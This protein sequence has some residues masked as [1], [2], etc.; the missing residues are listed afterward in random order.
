MPTRANEPGSA[1]RQGSATKRNVTKSRPPTSGSISN[2]GT[3]VRKSQKREPTSTELETRRDSKLSLQE[4]KNDKVEKSQ[5]PVDKN[6][7][8]DNDVQR[9]E[10]E[11]VV[12]VNDDVNDV[13]PEEQHVGDHEKDTEPVKVES[14][15]P[16]IPVVEVFTLEK[17]NQTCDEYADVFA[18]NKYINVHDDYPVEALKTLTNEVRDVVEEYK[19]ESAATQRH[20]E[21]LRERMHYVKQCI[22]ENIHKKS[23]ALRMGMCW[24]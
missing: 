11:S 21:T 3:Y 1:G 19:R 17:F 22:Q 18:S 13:E 9:Q 8:T 23:N 6:D 24:T 4:E 12:S 10:P 20:L 15:T 2:A 16:Q 5:E 7:V 14:P